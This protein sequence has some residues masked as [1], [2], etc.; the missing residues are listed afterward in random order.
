MLVY[1]PTITHI[2][3][4]VWFAMACF[5][6]GKLVRVTDIRI[7]MYMTVYMNVTLCVHGQSLQY[8]RISYYIGV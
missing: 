5:H 6:E 2:G 4:C 3:A 7:A 8:S 1:I